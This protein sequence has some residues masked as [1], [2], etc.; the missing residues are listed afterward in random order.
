LH[1][2]GQIKSLIAPAT[3]VKIHHG[4]ELVFL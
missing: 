3:K 1:C 2:C 4:G